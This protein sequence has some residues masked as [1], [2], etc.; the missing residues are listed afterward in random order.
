MQKQHNNNKTNLVYRDKP[1]VCGIEFET[2]PTQFLK[3]Q[4]LRIFLPNGLSPDEELYSLYS[5]VK[6]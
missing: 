1:S 3:K 6:I 4:N 5:W 2:T